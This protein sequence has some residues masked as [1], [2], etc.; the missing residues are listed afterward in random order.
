MKHETQCPAIKYIL[1]KKI[2]Y[3]LTNFKK[4][5]IYVMNIVINLIN[6]SCLYIYL[7]KSLNRPISQL[8]F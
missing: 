3:V 8:L 5:Y 1:K 7:R 6:M 4:I 2:E